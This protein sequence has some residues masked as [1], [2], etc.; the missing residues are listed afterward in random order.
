MYIG[1]VYVLF[2]NNVTTT[3]LLTI[4]FLGSRWKKIT[5]EWVLGRYIAYEKGMLNIK[6]NEKLWKGLKGIHNKYI[7]ILIPDIFKIGDKK[8]QKDEKFVSSRLLLT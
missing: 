2:N 8:K 4:P 1:E 6:K 3:I 7:H 5:F